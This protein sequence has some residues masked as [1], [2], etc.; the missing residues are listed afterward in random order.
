MR[1]VIRP[2][3]TQDQIIAGPKQETAADPNLSGR[4]LSQ[5]NAAARRP[6]ARRSISAQ[7]FVAG[8]LGG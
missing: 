2:T 5:V 4:V 1:E 7:D 8:P 6:A 3:E